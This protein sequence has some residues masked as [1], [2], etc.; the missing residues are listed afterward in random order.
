MKKEKLLM[1]PGPTMVPSTVLMAEGEPMIHHR[2]PEYSEIFKK[3]N[4]NLKTVF[5]TKNHV[6]TFPASG[7][8]G[9]EAS[10]VNFF[11]PGDKVLCVSI[12]LF[13]ERVATI[14]Q[15]FGLDVDK[16]SVTLGEAVDPKILEITLD[17]ED[18]KGLFV[19]HNETSTGATNDI[20]TIG[21]IAKKRDVLLLVDAVSSLGGIDIQTDAWG[22]DVVVTASQKA[23]MSPPGLAFISVSEKAWEMAKKSK[24]PKFYWDILKARESLEKASP[25]NPYTPAVSL[26]RACNKALEMIIEEGLQEVFNRHYKL[27]KATQ[28]AVTALGLEFFTASSARSNVITSITM[29][30]GIDGDKVKKI[31]SEK[32]DVIVAGGQGDLKGKLI[33]IGHMGY[34]NHGDIIQ[35]I[36]ALEKAMIEVGYTVEIG[37]GVKAALEILG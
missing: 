27:A 14:A 4:E 20:E 21:K 36:A 9:L 26:I 19:T 25:Q 13:G 22:L 5:Q 1:T 17:K 28:T 3:L 37:S 15:N 6:I 23:L 33:R 7:T 8:G 29:P 16:L 35:T 31:M 10:V 18:Y 30:E 12:G 11:S 32:Y 2:T 34:V 24:M